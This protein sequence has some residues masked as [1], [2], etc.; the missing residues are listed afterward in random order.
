MSL[1]AAVAMQAQ[2]LPPGAPLPSARQVIDRYLKASGGVAAFK[3]VRS[4]QGRG[5][6]SL[7]AQ[8]L[9][10]EFEMMAA[11]PNKSLTRVTVPGVGRLEAGCMTARS[12]TIDPVSGPAL[13][14]GREL[15]ERADE[16]WFDSPLHEST[17]VREMTMAGRETF[18]R[19]PAFRIKVVLASGNEQFELFDEET[20]LQIGLEATRA[21]SLGS[22]P[23]TTIYR[24]YQ[25]FGAI[26]L[27]TVQVQRILG[28]EQVVTVTSYEFNA[29]PGGAFD[30]P[31]VIK[32]LV[33]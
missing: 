19:R 5:R 10:G 30:L 4:V 9:S 12:V 8:S 33:K 32:A 18:D 3:A 22:A 24:E 17:F 29:V 27:P 2:P 7:A 14:T 13:V 25:T 20:G 26:K 31:A 23:V 28:I 1:L 21:T 11:R 16:A 15:L 6:L